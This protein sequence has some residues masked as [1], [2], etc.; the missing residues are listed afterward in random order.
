MQTKKRTVVILEEGEGIE[1]QIDA[2]QFVGRMVITNHEHLFRVETSQR[3]EVTEMYGDADNPDNLRIFSTEDGY[4]IEGKPPAEGH[5]G[6]W[7]I[8]VSGWSQQLS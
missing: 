6:P 2:C 8:T 3:V 7:V 5:T 4:M 1:I